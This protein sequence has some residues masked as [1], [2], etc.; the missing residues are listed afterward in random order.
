MEPFILWGTKMVSLADGLKKGRVW[1]SLLA[2][3]LAGT[4]LRSILVRVMFLQADEE[5]FGYD[6]YYIHLGRS[7]DFVMSKIGAYIAYPYL[8]SWWYRVF[9]VSLTSARF[10]TVLCWALVIGFTYLIVLK[11]TR[12]RRSSAAAS[13]LLALAPFPLRYGVMVL[14]QPLAWVFVSGS[15]LLLVMAMRSK[16]W[17]LY[18]ASGT[19]AAIAVFA[20][21]SALILLFVVIPLLVWVNRG[22]LRTLVS[23]TASYITGFAAPLGMVAVGLS[24]YLGWDRLN[25]LG[26]LRIPHFTTEYMPDLGSSRM[27]GNAVFAL[28]PTIAKGSTLFIPMAMALGIMLASLMKDRW[29]AVYIGAFL[30]P[31]MVRVAF[32]QAASPTAIFVIMVLPAFVAGIVR[33]GG[34]KGKP[35]TALSILLGSSAAFS[36]LILTGDIWNVLIYTSV[37]AMFLVYLEDRIAGDIS[38]SIFCA[39]GVAMAAVI[40]GKEPQVSRV[41][42][43]TLSV[44]II[45]FSSSLPFRSRT[46]RQ[47]HLGMFAPGILLILLDPS[48]LAWTAAAV[49]FGAGALMVL[50]RDRPN[51]WR[52]ARFPLALMALAGFAF[53]PGSLSVPIL[54]ASLVMVV[55]FWFLTT[56]GRSWAFPG[57]MIATLAAGVVLLADGGTMLQAGVAMLLVLSAC[58]SITG[59]RSL[60]SRWS[61]MIDPRVTLLLVL[62]TIGYIAF[63]VYYGWTEVYLTEFIVVACISTGLLIHIMAN[64]G[65]GIILLGDGSDPDRGDRT[66]LRVLPLPSVQRWWKAAFLALILITI[67]VSTGSFLDDNWFMEGSMDKR[68]YMR[69]IVEVADWIKDNSDPG[70]KVLAW[71]CYALEAERETIIDVSNAQIYNGKK[72]AEEMEAQ[73]VSLFVHCWY[74][75]HGLWEDQPE[76]QAYI[77]ANFLIDKV[78]DGNLCYIRVRS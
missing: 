8:L 47:M 48:V 61:G 33:T 50:F 34:D 10:F 18:I 12:D 1:P 13:L 11:T 58:L 25:E 4:I 9:D 35:F 3:V 65:K 40:A 39:M 73:N 23:R 5:I 74:T 28:Q 27:F 72:V 32:D 41:L 45:A 68:P 37:A 14:S 60:A 71:H 56:F 67:P 64:K 54:A 42:L 26:W 63:Y 16:R 53:V 59:L 2:T 62:S 51:I 78:I 49:L 70:E 31:M 6:A 75:D 38:S 66:I 77:L 19:T 57:S 22:R 15:L 55:V 29:K 20:R 43:T 76:F 52:K 21:R 44:W 30:Y 7:W 17:Y 46:A 69:T 24:L 36:S